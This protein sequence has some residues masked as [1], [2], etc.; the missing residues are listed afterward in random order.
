[1][2]QILVLPPYLHQGHGHH[3][4]ETLNSIAVSEDV[5]DVTSKM[6][7]KYLQ[8]I[9]ASIDTLRLLAFEPI[10][11]TIASVASQ[12]DQGNLSK[13]TYEFHSDPPASMVEDVRKKLKINK[14]QLLRCWEVLIFLNL[15]P[16]DPQCIDNYITLISDRIKV[17]IF[18]KIASAAGKR[19]IE[20]Q[21]NN[22]SDKYFVM[23]RT[24]PAVED[25]NLEDKPDVDEDKK[26]WLVQM[27]DNRMAW[28]MAVA[29]MISLY[30]KA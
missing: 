24:Q 21:S 27:L 16:G 29:K 26:R 23:F 25:D 4:L 5:Y 20:V 8:Y 30:S 22:G 15:S 3:L 12:L 10:M 28:I 2:W 19:V 6:L 18:G 7:H 11:P 13:R 1:M 14:K 17:V 9:R